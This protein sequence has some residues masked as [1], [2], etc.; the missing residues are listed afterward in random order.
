MQPLPSVAK[1][2]TMVM[3]EEKQREGLTVK[4]TVSTIFNTYTNNSRPST[5]SSNSAPRISSWTPFTWKVLSIW[6]LH[7]RI[8]KSQLHPSLAG[9]QQVTAVMYNKDGSTTVCSSY[10][11]IREISFKKREVAYGTLYDGLY[12]ISPPP[13]SLSH[14]SIILHNITSPS[15]WH[16]RLGHSSFIV[17]KKISH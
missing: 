15:T 4:P 10:K 13:S 5:N 12:F 16:L 17:L 1:A 9:V 7:K 3:Q 11:T 2:Y 6:L 8:L 14:P